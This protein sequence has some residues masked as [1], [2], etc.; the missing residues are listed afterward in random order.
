MN[1]RSSKGA[2]NEWKGI[3][4]VVAS[5][6]L[7]HTNDKNLYD[8]IFLPDLTF[9]FIHCTIKLT[10]PI[11][12][13]R[14]TKVYYNCLKDLEKNEDQE[15]I[16]EKRNLWSAVSLLQQPKILNKVRSNVNI[17]EHSMYWSRI[18]LVLT[19]HV[20]DRIYSKSLLVVLHQLEDCC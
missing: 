7:D 18:Q 2:L 15:K 10:R 16:L 1:E 9:D 20:F 13:K 5:V 11:S 17:K 19:L 6:S 12:L 3:Q 4:N 8:Y 14:K